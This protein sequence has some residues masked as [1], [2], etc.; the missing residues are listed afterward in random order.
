VVIRGVVF[1][2][3]DTLYLER[4]YIRSGFDHVARTAARSGEE[5][6]T[7]S[8]WLSAAFESGV[9][10]DTFDRLR[11]AFPEVAERFSTA[12]LV[13]AYRGHQPSIQLMPGTA[14]LLDVLRRRGSRLAVLSDGP[15][16]SQAAKASALGLDRWFDPV[17]L[18]WSLGP[19]FAKPG[20]G[21]FELIARG[22]DLA[23][24]Q[25]AYVADN[26]GKD[27]IGPRRLGWSTVRLVCP[28][29]LH[30]AVEPADEDHR[31]AIVIEA[32]VDLV[33]VLQIGD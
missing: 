33:Q 4:D 6:G 10:G 7:L 32:M 5:V 22:W 27:F 15:A 31:P 28:G 3:D 13:G 8:A 25:L 9:R 26:P 16:E 11:L 18:T 14:E 1:D 2:I 29:Q 12:D 23:S 19:G 24:P 17:L 20:T 30:D 21:G